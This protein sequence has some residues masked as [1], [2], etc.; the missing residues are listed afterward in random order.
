M[1]C[2][3]VGRTQKR[4]RK[5]F[6]RCLE[7]KKDFTVRTGTLLERSHVPLHKWLYAMCLFIAN[8]KGIP[9]TLLAK[10]L[11]VTQKTAWYML[12]R[13]RQSCNGSEAKLEG[14]VEADETFIGGREKNKH[15]KKQLHAG[16]GAVGKSVVFGVRER[17]TGRTKLE[18]VK[19]RKHKTLRTIIDKTVDKQALLMTD[20][21]K[22]YKGIFSCMDMIVSLRIF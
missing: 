4:V 5:G 3:V 17:S 20:E 7:C 15:A 12:Q 8:C 11:G 2:G 21:H 13:I 18:V 16:R 19:D 14:V 1:F 10:Q 6:Y 22:A 9:S